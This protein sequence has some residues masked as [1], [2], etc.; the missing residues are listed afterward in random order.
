MRRL[1]EEGRIYVA[2]ELG[3]TVQVQEQAQNRVKSTYITTEPVFF[4]VEITNK[5]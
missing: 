4:P 2:E 1:Q 3:A 5:I